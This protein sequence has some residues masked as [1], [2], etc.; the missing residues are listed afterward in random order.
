MKIVYS[1]Q[2]VK[3]IASMDSATKQRI[4]VAIEAF[5]NGD[6]IP[7]KGTDSLFRLRVG[8]WRVVFSYLDRC[9]IAIERISTRGDAYRRL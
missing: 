1:K 2:A 9:T 6:I 5:P 7:L 4:R 3:S 8:T